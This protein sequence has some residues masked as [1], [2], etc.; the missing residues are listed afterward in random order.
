MSDEKKTPTWRMPAKLREN[1]R[2]DLQNI[3]DDITEPYTDYDIEVV[4]NKI[5]A[6]MEK[7]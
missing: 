6:V 4:Q 7:L 1:L 5:R 2:A 3:L